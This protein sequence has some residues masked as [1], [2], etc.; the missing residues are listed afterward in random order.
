MKKILVPTDFSS[1]AANALNFAVQASRFY[2]AEIILLHVIDRTEV[3]YGEYP[4]V[5][6]ERFKAAAND[7]QEKLDQIKASIAETESIAIRTFQREGEVDELILEL[8]DE[9]EI[10]LIVMGTFGINGIKDRIWGSKTAALTGKS[11]VPVM[12]IPYEYDWKQPE[13]MLLA[14]SRFEEDR[15]VLKPIIDLTGAFKADLFAVVFTDEDHAD[16]ALLMERGLHM[17]SYEVKLKKLL[18]TESIITGHLSGSKFEDTLQDYI[19]NNG[20]DMLAMITYQ[21]SLWDRIFRPS[22][23]RRMSYHTTIPLLVI[24]AIKDVEEE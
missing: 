22:A 21:R 15:E 19:Q 2:R 10:D 9:M 5:I 4:D 18:N 6:Q 17:T 20:I 12:I 8:S 24:P 11:S 23:T 3:L 1:C 7:A 16:A 14:T 13:K